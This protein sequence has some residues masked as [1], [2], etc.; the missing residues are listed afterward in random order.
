MIFRILNGKFIK[1]SHHSTIFPEGA[2][3]RVY[4]GRI[5]PSRCH[6]GE[7]FAESLMND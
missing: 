4:L 5:T 3:Y 6:F 2:K 7:K 1:F